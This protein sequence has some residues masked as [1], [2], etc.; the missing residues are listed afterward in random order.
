MAVGL[1]LSVVAANPGLFKYIKGRKPGLLYDSG[2]QVTP[3]N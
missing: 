2:A 3:N 1:V